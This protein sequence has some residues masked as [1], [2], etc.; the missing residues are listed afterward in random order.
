MSTDS[1]ESWRSV[2]EKVLNRDS[3]ECQ[4]CGRTNDEHIEKHDRGLEAHHIIPQK[5]GG[6]DT[7]DNLITVCRGCHRTLES[8][9]AKAVTDVIDPEQANKRDEALDS[10]E[11]L[12][13]RVSMEYYDGW[14][15]LQHGPFIPT[16]RRDDD[17]YG[18]S[19][20]D[21]ESFSPRETAAFIAGQVEIL[22]F[23]GEQLDSIL[24]RSG[25]IDYIEMNF[26]RA[27]WDN[28]TNCRK[29]G[30]KHRVD[31]SCECEHDE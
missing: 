14:S 12:H 20:V 10:V 29:C 24:L 9:H 19:L 31:E 4:F 2:R 13:D 23:V 15:E 8:T 6:S 27:W 28:W 1:Q 25:Q 26:T 22:Q 7:L 21:R 18:M 17:G 11:S 30:R 3:H 16:F 5:D